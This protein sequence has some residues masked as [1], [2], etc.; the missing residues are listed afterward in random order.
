MVVAVSPSPNAVGVCVRPFFVPAGVP[1]ERL[2]ALRAAFDRTM[3]DP[4]YVAA[5][6]KQ[7]LDISP[8]TGEK[9]Q[10]LIAKMYA[11]PK[12]LQEKARHAL[13]TE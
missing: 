5:A 6:K 2:A 9:V 1:R 3:K 7:K 10:Q 4:D 13:Y 11:A 12:V 8:A